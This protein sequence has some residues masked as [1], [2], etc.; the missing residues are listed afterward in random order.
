[1]IS[2]V[3]TNVLLDVFLADERYGPR[4]E[5]GLRDA[6][7]RGAILI[8]DVVYAELAPAFND[9]VRLDGALREINVTISPIDTDIAYEAGLRWLQYRQAGRTEKAD[10]FRLPDR[11]SC[12]CYGRYFSYPRP[13]FLCN[14]L[15]GIEGILI[16]FD[17]CVI[18]PTFIS[19]PNIPAPPARTATWK[20]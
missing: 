2:A 10:Y 13:G 18:M 8:C 16:W 15:P 11:R 1:M 6:Y 19:T 17:P 5:E 20:T 4:S 12:R 3:D 14:L 9:R 7:D